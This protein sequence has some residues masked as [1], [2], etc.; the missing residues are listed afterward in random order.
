MKP[1]RKRGDPC[2]HAVT[3]TVTEK[4]SWR[5]V[6]H[7][8]ILRHCPSCTRT[9]SPPARQ[10]GQYS[11]LTI[12]CVFCV[13]LLRKHA[14]TRAATNN[15][16]QAYTHLL[17][18]NPKHLYVPQHRFLAL[19]LYLYLLSCCVNDVRV[20]AGAGDREKL[21]RSERTLCDTPLARLCEAPCVHVLRWSQCSRVPP[22]SSYEVDRMVVRICVR[23]EM[24]KLPLNASYILLTKKKRRK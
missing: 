22:C 17:P 9:P 14:R 23:S 7:N 6:L 12:S 24:V 19:S 10:S 18:T 15:T 20:Q 21:I 1:I 13:C 3:N 8:W 4:E 2:F 5:R 16:S 11:C